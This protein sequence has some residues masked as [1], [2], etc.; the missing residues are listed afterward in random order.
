MVFTHPPTVPFKPIKGFGSA[1]TAFTLNRSYL[2]SLGFGCLVY[3]SSTP[4]FSTGLNT[5]SYS[6]LL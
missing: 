5:L 1:N 2:D 6:N 4:K 3:L